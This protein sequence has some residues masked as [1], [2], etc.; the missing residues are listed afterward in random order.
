MCGYRGHAVV[1]DIHMKGCFQ[2]RRKHI[3]FYVF[4]MILVFGVSGYAQSIGESSSTATTDKLQTSVDQ[5]DGSGTQSKMSQPVGSA[6]TKERAAAVDLPLS[7]DKPWTA[8]ISA[9]Y[10]QT[11]LNYDDQTMNAGLSVSYQLPNET[12]LIGGIGYTTTTDLE[13]TDPISY[14]LSDLSVN[15]ISPNIF[16]VQVKEDYAVKF[17]LVTGATL[18][19]SETSQLAGQRFSVSAALDSKF[20]LIANSI[21]V[22]RLGVRGAS[23]EYDTADAFGFAPNSPFGLITQAG[24]KV[25]IGQRL[26]VNSAYQVYTFYDY[27][28]RQ[29]Q[30]QTFSFSTR[31]MVN[32]ATALTGGYYWK[33]QILTN[34][35]IF[36][37]ANSSMSLG[38]E[39][40]L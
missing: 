22:A 18:P 11:F 6:V 32:E 25:P 40:S 33:D 3:Q 29:D 15:W 34:N 19:T 30:V 12:M 7:K 31:W 23:H 9:G 10:G 17:D 28:N 16:S 1:G 24:L 37:D 14:G 20:S 13:A 21:F 27:L 4:A 26:L 39:I 2:F 8:H 38:L 36:D 35:E 5:E